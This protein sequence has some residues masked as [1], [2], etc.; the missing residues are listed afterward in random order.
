MFIDI[1]TIVIVTLIG[2]AVWQQFN[3]KLLQED[4]DEV[5]DKH[6][7]FVEVV[8]AVFRDILVAAEEKDD[9]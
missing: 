9:D 3:I 1:P 4:I 5:T 8:D 7:S 6:N 2:V